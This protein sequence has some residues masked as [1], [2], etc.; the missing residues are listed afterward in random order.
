MRSESTPSG[1]ATIRVIVKWPRRIAICESSMLPS[2][3]R[4]A[5][6]TAATMPGLSRPMADTAK[7][8]IGSRIPGAS[9]VSR[10][11]LLGTRRGRFAAVAA[12][13]SG[14]AFAA[15][16]FWY[17]VGQRGRSRRARTTTPCCVTSTATRGEYL[18]A[19]ILQAVGMLLL[20]VVAVHLYRAAQGPQPGPGSRSCS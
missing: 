6:A 19:S 13:V 4:S 16:A 1:A 12:M 14:I 20:V 7:W 8:R 9:D 2:W 10:T 17:Q 18:G 3:A 5:S 15:G 11:A